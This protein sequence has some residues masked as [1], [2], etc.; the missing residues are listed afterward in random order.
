MKK[1]YFYL[2]AAVMMIGAT[3][4]QK[5]AASDVNANGEMKSFVASLG[6][7]VSRTEL[8]ESNKVMWNADDKIRIFTKE[9]T[10]GAI[11]VG[12][13][14]E[15][16]S[17]ATFTTTDAFEA[18]QTGY[19][20]MYPEV[21]YDLS[22]WP[23]AKVNP[24][25]TYD[26]GIWKVPVNIGIEQDV[27][28]GAWDEKYNYMVAY[29]ENNKLSFQAATAMIKFTYTG[30]AG[31]N[32][33]FSA[34]GAPLAGE[35]TL[36]YDTA[37]GSISYSM[38]GSNSTEVTLFGL[39]AGQTY[40]IPI[41]PGTVSSFELTGYNAMYSPETFYRYEGDFEFK[42]GKIY[43]VK[44]DVA[45]PSP[46]TLM[47]GNGMV[48]VP[49]SIDDETGYHYAKNVAWCENVFFYAY[50]M[51]EGETMITASKA[52]VAGEW[53]A[54]VNPAM[55]G[56]T[57]PDG[58]LFD[59][60]LS[61]DTSMMCVVA[62]GSEV[63]AIPSK[64]HIYVY[65]SDN[66]G[67]VNL[68]AWDVNETYLN[69]AWPGAALK[70]TTVGEVE[71][72]VF[73]IPNEYEGQNINFIINDGNGVQ[74]AD[75]PMT[76]NSDVYY[77]TSGEVIADPANP[78]LPTTYK[79]YAYNKAG[80]A[81]LYL[82]CWNATSSTTNYTGG[83]WPG[84]KL[85]ETTQINGY[86]YYI[87]EM[88][89][90]ATDQ[91]IKMLFNSGNNGSQTAD[92]PVI[93]LDKD[94]YMSVNGGTTTV[95]EDPNNPENVAGNERSIYVTT[96]LSWSKMNLYTWSP[97]LATWPGKAITTK[98][99]INGTTY[100]VLKLGADY[101]G[102]TFG[103]MIFNN[104]SSQT[105]DITTGTTLSKDLFFRIETSQTGGKYKVTAIADPRQ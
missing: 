29:S 40:Y 62:A 51:N 56:F 52:L 77:Y 55:A 24:E 85:T 74:T 34:T 26:N 80:W 33:T 75:I 47:D 44:S 17:Y 49:M 35:A 91:K 41:Y 42:A 98:E 97:E 7:N 46:Y 67:S 104:G 21:N 57:M 14:T 3:A 11:F 60:Y 5:D 78:V 18:S 10:A 4:C 38:T 28:A 76:V 48:Y 63:P 31:M 43:T 20:A 100:W 39:E 64:Y 1:F 27:V 95:I 53:Q 88:P 65:N 92:S 15:A 2:V 82:W 90:S 69:G 99:T 37:D 71:Y 73:D 61:E 12:D 54:T 50:D 58:E 25:V 70:K 36:I 96:S 72:Y 68:Y 19:F 9:K 79:I 81:N 86:T 16:A 22:S 45:T 94:V 102:A 103:G 23:A 87:Y 32:A 93:T 89:T 6:D 59:V 13:A 101:D 66:W 30:G 84:K 105:V 83:T 8:G